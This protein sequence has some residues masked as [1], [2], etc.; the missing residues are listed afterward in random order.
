LQA[1]GTYFFGAVDVVVNLN[2]EASYGIEILPTAGTT[3][4]TQVYNLQDTEGY[5]EWQMTSLY[6]PP[7]T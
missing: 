6:L 2:E 5:R 3:V 1:D 4:G 7:F